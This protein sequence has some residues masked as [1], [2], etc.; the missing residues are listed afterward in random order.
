MKRLLL[1]SALFL[2]SILIFAQTFSQDG[3]SYKVTSTT[4]YTVEVTNSLTKPSGNIT[5]P[6]S[7]EYG[8]E[9]YK[10]T[11]IGFQ[12]LYFSSNLTSVT[13]PNTVTYIGE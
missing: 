7:V 3:I 10:V 5:I 6:E 11:G 4:D 2:C 12:A 1:F 8:G 9:P 13:I